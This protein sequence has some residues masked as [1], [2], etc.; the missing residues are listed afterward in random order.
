MSTAKREHKRDLVF[1]GHVATLQKEIDKLTERHNFDKRCLTPRPP[2]HMRSPMHRQVPLHRLSQFSQLS[3]AAQMRCARILRPGLP[4]NAPW[5]RRKR[6][7]AKKFA[8][9]QR[10]NVKRK[11]KRKE[12]RKIRMKDHEMEQA[13]ETTKQGGILKETTCHR[14]LG[15]RKEDKP[16][17]PAPKELSWAADVHYVER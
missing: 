2:I 4:R 8:A 7:L 1:K 10:P 16:R 14:L 12:T 9:I 6:Q 15:V 5:L 17:F 3:L 11:R 13:Q